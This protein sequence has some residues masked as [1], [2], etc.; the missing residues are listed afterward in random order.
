MMIEDHSGISSWSEDPAF[1]ERILPFAQA[2][3]SGS[4]YAFWKH[5]SEDLSHYPVVVFG[6]EGGVH[7]VA[8][9]FREFLRLLTYDTE[10]SVD[11][12]EV[13]FYKDDDYEE[14]EDHEAYMDWLKEKVNLDVEADPEAIITSAQQK[15]KSDFD[16][17]FQLYY[18]D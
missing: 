9:N 5:G 6:D 17:W 1:L 12:D 10:I 14:S 16:A 2:N 7:V 15:Y 13:Y 18:N 4:I 8:E 11:F 3:G